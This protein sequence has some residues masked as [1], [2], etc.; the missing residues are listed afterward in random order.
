M[1]ILF[2][3]KQHYD[4]GGIQASTDQLARRLARRG[5]EVVVLAHISWDGP[6]HEPLR[7]TVRRE[8]VDAYAAYSVDLLPPGPALGILLRERRPD[9]VVVNAGGRWWHDWTRPLFEATPPDVPVALYVRDQQAIELLADGS[10]RPDLV[11]ANAR[12][13]ADAI[14]ALGQ[15]AVVVPSVVDLEPY[16]VDPTGEA[17]V[18]INPVPMKGVELAFALAAERPDIRFEFRESWQ[19][20]REV[21]AH[22]A[23]RAARLDNVELLPGADDPAEPYRRARLLLV[24]Y[25]DG[26]RPRVVLEAQCSGIPILALDEPAL[27][28]TVGPGGILVP[29]GAP[30][31]SWADALDRLWYDAAAHRALACE[32][33]RWSERDEVDPER[34]TDA[35]VDAVTGPRPS[36]RTVRIRDASAPVASVVVPVRDVAE[37]IEDQL[38]ALAGQTFAGPWEVVIADNGSTD[39]TRER[40]EAHRAALPGLRIVDAG[41]RRGVAFARNVGLGAARGEVLLICDGD[42]IVAADWLEQMV[43]ALDEHP[44]VTGY[45]D[46]VSMNTPAQYEWLG[47]AGREGPPVGYGFLPYAPGGNIG[48]WREV[49]ESLGG[50]DE[51]LQRA[52]DIDFS[53]RASY[54][55]VGVHWEPAAVLHRRLRT[56]LSGTFRAGYRGGVAE[57]G[58]YRRHRDRGMTAAPLDRVRD[59]YRWLLKS[60]PDVVAG[61]ADRYHWA[62]HA[63]K[64]LGRVVGSARARA[65]Y[66]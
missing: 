18:F 66:L 25:E 5:H 20:P 60:V 54:L 12:A 2:A 59:E 56:T 47:D 36:R 22:L 24:P 42:D 6:P 55:G 8:P 15:R 49:F 9:L 43:A 23:A 39:A 35:F 14:E 31:E 50:F 51:E 29:R 32:A 38:A 61:R 4:L 3:G 7:R 40:I 44:I 41:A 63:G 1:R 21:R 58:L 33:L 64:R 62:H 46:I 10:V 37:T 30:L 65:A 27:R 16:R 48:M 28:E 17:V 53:W 52:E 34:I 45:I 57:P 26:N 11:L 13:H 19:L